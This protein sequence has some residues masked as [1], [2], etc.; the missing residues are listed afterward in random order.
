MTK[1]SLAEKF[2]LLYCSAGTYY[3]EICRIA[4]VEKEGSTQFILKSDTPVRLDSAVGIVNRY[5]L[6]GPGSNPCGG[7]IFRTRPDRP[8]CPPSLLYSG[9]RLFPGCKAAGAWR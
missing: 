2:K 1:C 6:D 5:G 7:G 4:A 3:Q 8:W 9:Y